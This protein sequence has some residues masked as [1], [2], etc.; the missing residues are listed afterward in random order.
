MLPQRGSPEDAYRVVEYLQTKP[1]GEDL[2]DIRA[3]L[4][5][6]LTTSRKL[7]TYEAWGVIDSTQ[8][9]IKLEPEARDLTNE[10]YRPEF[11]R[12]VLNEIHPY[13]KLL[14]SAYHNEAE[15]ITK[16]KAATFLF[17][18]FPDEVGTDSNSLIEEMATCLFKVCDEAGIGEYIVGRGGKS[19]RLEIS[20]DSL[21]DF[22]SEFV[23]GSEEDETDVQSHSSE[24]EEGVTTQEEDEVDSA[25]D[26][27]DGQALSASQLERLKEEKGVSP[28]FHIDIAIHISPDADADQIDQIFE[29]MANH[30]GNL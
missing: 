3:T 8:G 5:D 22:I 28:S 2:D 1:T 14:E 9:N 16:T 11:F 23:H 13:R 25:G 19:T 21:H 18:N 7:R 27:T 12:E 10:S 29:S 4:Q 6:N 15:Q 26:S 30:L 20:E 24:D 17:D